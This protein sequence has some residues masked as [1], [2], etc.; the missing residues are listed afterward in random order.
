MLLRTAAAIG[1]SAFFLAYSQETTFRTRQ[2]KADFPLTA[3]PKNAVWAAA[4]SV[5]TSHDRYGKPVTGAE[6]VIRSRWTEKHLYF[7]F[8][9]RYETLHLKSNPSVK[10]ETW[11]LWDYDVVEVFIGHDLERIHLYKEFEVSPQNEWVDL[12]VDKSKGEGKTV[13]WKWNSGFESRTR[14]DEAAKTWICEMRIPWPSIDARKPRAGNELRLNLYRIEGAPPNRK[15]IAWQPV[16]ALS[17]H[18]P[19]RF[20]RLRLE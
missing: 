8:V 6:T 19:E 7:L 2:I 10:E 18:T 11:G 3:N 14:V 16:Q 9:S 15:F 17:Y 4:P 20:G 12:D 5:T 13:D 1:A